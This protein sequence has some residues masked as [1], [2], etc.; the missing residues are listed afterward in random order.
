MN[1]I[2]NSKND[3]MIRRLRFLMSAL[4][5]G[6]FMLGLFSC[7][8]WTFEGEQTVP[9]YIR[10]DSITL[11]ADYFT[12][13]EA[14]HNIVDA[15]VYLDDQVVGGF[16][17]PAVIPVLKQGVHKLTIYAGIKVNGIS[18]SRAP[19]PFFQPLIINEFNLVPDS[20]VTINPVVSYYDPNTITMRWMEDFENATLSIEPTAASDTGIVRVVDPEAL[21][22]QYSSYSGSVVLPHNKAFTLVNSQELTDLPGL[23]TPVML[24]M[25][26][27]CTDTFLVG[28]VYR[29]NN[30][31]TELPL[32]HV[33]PTD[34]DNDPP[35]R[36]NKIYIN[37]GPNVTDNPHADYFKVY[38]ARKNDRT[39]R[40]EKYYFDN[41]KL[42]YRNRI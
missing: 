23:G 25:D 27:N 35:A 10:I 24:E 5:V 8:Q 39:G 19:Y 4:A 3:G 26:Y 11:N 38:F 30:V 14:T 36:W 34:F 16:E 28:M 12:Y 32:V 7:K 41:I 42:I 21:I 2:V 33:N 31:I 13:G 9:S 22:S 40:T 6:F 20:I 29:Q 1:Y 15:W 17:L 37:L 18:A